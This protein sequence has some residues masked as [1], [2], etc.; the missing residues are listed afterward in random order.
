MG[1][2]QKVSWRTV[3]YAALGTVVAAASVVA[4]ISSDGVRPTSLTSNAATRW[5]VDQVNGTVVLVDGLAGRVVAKVDAE[6]QGP[7]VAVQGGGGAFLVAPDQGSVRSISTAKL[8]LGTAQPVASLLDPDPKFGVG[9]SGLTV[10]SSKA[11]TAN[12]VIDDVARPVKIVVSDKALV[13]ADGS[14]WL[15]TGTQATH[16]SVDGSKTTTRMPSAS[17]QTTTVG[18]RGVAYDNKNGILRW[19]GGNDIDL[20]QSIR[21]SSE[22][23]LQEPGDDAHCVWLGVDDTLKCIGPTKIE[24]TLTIPGMQLSTGDRLAVAGDAAV[25]V[26]SGNEIRRIDL[27]SREIAKDKNEPAVL[28]GADAL[29]I[30]ASGNLVWLDDRGGDHAWVVNRFGINAIAKDD[31]RAQLLDAQGQVKANGDGTAGPGT[32]NGNAA[33]E[34]TAN[35]NDG[36]ATEDPPH[37]VADSVTAR[38]GATVTIPVTSNDWD[39]DGD[40]FAVSAVG[41]ASG[42]SA[43]SGTTD[44]LNGDTVTYLPKPGFSGIDNFDYTIVDPAGRTSTATVTVELFPPGSPNQPPIARDDKAFT[45]VGHPITIDVLANDIDPE[46]DTLSVAPF[47]QDAVGISDALGPTNLPALKYTPPPVPGI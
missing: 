33:G 44:I 1:Q 40:P 8:Q 47:R 19:I 10:V 27:E 12:V 22:A 42:R 17:T 36:N 20:R 16:V 7:E 28:A 2:L 24:Q 41:S 4:I 14:M 35:H 21:N 26:G 15:I 18:A 29:S 13:A 43:A 45:R 39:P 32:G 6:S 46:R 9:S 37:A 11:G 5:L 38:A 23:V 30:T 31:S 3:G 25:V 34:D